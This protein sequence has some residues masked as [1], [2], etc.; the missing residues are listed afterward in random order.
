VGDWS[1]PY[2]Q[3]R[4]DSG[5]LGSCSEGGSRSVMENWRSGGHRPGPECVK[6]MLEINS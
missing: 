3:R 5:T 1:Q 4:R 6:K 2:V